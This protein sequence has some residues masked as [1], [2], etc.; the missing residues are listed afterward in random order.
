MVVGIYRN[1]TYMYEGGLKMVKRIREYSMEDGDKYE[2][3][4]LDGYRTGKGTLIF[5]Q[6]EQNIKVN[7]LKNEFS[8]FGII[9]YGDGDEY[10]GEFLRNNENGEGKI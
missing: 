4:L 1:E 10:E 9:N 7:F 5:M 8:G 3:I 6:V 2:E